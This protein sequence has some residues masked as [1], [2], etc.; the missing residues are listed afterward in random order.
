[1][2]QL[3]ADVHS[4]ERRVQSILTSITDGFVAVDRN[5]RFTYVNSTYLRLVGSVYA[6]P[7]ELIGENL[8]EKF[9]DIVGTDVE[10]AYRGAMT[11]QKAVSF[12]L[13]YESIATWLEVRVYPAPGTLSIYA[14]D[15]SERKTQEES[16]RSLTRQVSAQAEIFD[17]ALSNITDFAYILDRAGRFVYANKPLLDLWKLS[18]D[19]AKGK[20]F[21]ELGYPTALAT[22][23]QREIDQVFSTGKPVTG[24]TA[25]VGADGKEGYYEYIFSPV[26]HTDGAVDVIAGSTRVITARKKEEVIGER[27]RLVLQLIVEDA[28]LCKV[29]D[30]LARMVELEALSQMRACI[31]LS[32]TACVQEDDPVKESEAD[33]LFA[34]CRKN[35]AQ[36]GLTAAWS[37]P[38]LSSQGCCTRPKKRRGRR[39][40]ASW[41]SL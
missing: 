16:L 9:P 31:T 29:F 8:W 5:W 2:R 22:K 11:D 35:A 28:P 34:E 36:L 30:A 26:L 41:P 3:L 12:E 6:S 39:T 18:L 25:Y 27:R 10:R 40:G 1:V 23:L 14:R 15:I 17:I 7:A 20:T 13:F 33:P 32:M 19:E 24:E 38:I 37:T 4:S 21:F